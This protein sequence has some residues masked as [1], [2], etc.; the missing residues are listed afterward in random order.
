MKQHGYIGYSLAMRLSWIVV[1]H[2]EH[3]DRVSA[4]L[5]NALQWTVRYAQGKEK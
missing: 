2:N 1:V 5:S 3:L 4:V